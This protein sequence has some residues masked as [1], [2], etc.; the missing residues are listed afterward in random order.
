[1]GWEDSI[2]YSGTP[3]TTL[4]L[5]ASATI[6]CGAELIT[7]NYSAKMATTASSAKPAT[8]SSSAGSVA[9]S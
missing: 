9:T 5:A 2:Q 7:I 4:S 8:M 6:S 1:M 3:V